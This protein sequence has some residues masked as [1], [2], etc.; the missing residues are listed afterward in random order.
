MF[1]GRDLYLGF[2][3]GIPILTTYTALEGLC[4]PFKKMS[5]NIFNFV[6]LSVVSLLYGSS[7]YFIKKGQGQGVIILVTIFNLVVTVSLVGITVA[8]LPRVNG[9]LKHINDTITICRFHRSQQT[10][11]FSHMSGSFFEPYNRVREP[12]L[13]SNNIQYN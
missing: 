6:L 4:R 9:L 2:A 5:L 10:E 1:R 8:Q 11:E 7:W 12:L 13:S 3:I